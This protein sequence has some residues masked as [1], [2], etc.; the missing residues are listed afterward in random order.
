MEG[1]NKIKEYT[2]LRH[3]NH[4]HLRRHHRRRHRHNHRFVPRAHK[5]HVMVMDDNA[6][7]MGSVRRKLMGFY[8]KFK[9]WGVLFEFLI[10]CY[11]NK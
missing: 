7:K 1:R 6:S 3:H 4:H 5:E 10:L 8:F 2:H 9:F 11:V